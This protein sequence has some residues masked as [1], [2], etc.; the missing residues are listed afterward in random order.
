MRGSERVTE[1]TKD[2]VHLVGR[3]MAVA[4]HIRLEI[5][6]LEKLHR[7]EGHSRRAI[8]TGGDYLNDVVAFDA[9]ADLRLL[10][11]PPPHRLV[12]HQRRMHHF[13]GAFA[14]GAEL[15]RD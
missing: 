13:E 14:T 7:D 5:L 9:R 8:D 1:L 3:Q 6:P 2:L 12:A 4:S 11:E 10:L 15:L